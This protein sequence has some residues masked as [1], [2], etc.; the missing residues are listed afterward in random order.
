MFAGMAPLVLTRI[1]TLQ[2]CW[3]CQARFATC[4]RRLTDNL[5]GVRIM[6]AMPSESHPCV[7]PLQAPDWNISD[8]LS[9]R[10]VARAADAADTAA[11]LCPPAQPVQRNISGKDRLSRLKP[12]DRPRA[13]LDAGAVAG[14]VL[15]W[16]RYQ[17]ARP[18][19]VRPN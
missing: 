4:V 16:R 1:S 9:S 14:R 5:I 13:C 8:F 12:R 11:A 18:G 7:R 6:A 19:R 17:L 3:A 10:G 15:Y 2:G